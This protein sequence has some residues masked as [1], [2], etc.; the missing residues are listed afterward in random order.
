MIYPLQ[1]IAEWDVIRKQK[2]KLIN[3]SNTRE[4]NT[5]IDWDYRLGG[6]LILNK[7]IQ[8]KLDLPTKGLF[9][10]TDVHTNGNVTFRKGEVT[11][12]INIHNIKPFHEVAY[13]FS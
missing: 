3:I 1:Y 12:R 11:K 10:I 4:N 2:Q 7:D 8:S 13:K 5:R 9:I 6:I